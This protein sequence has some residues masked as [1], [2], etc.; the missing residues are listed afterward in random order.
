MYEIKALYLNYLRRM[1][2]VLSDGEERE[3]ELV[4][5]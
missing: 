4:G 2:D 1:G 3:G 5:S